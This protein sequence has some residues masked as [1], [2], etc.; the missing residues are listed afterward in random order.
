MEQEK[1]DRFE[2]LMESDLGDPEVQYQIGLCY[3][4]GE[5]VEQDGAKAEMWLQRAA[6]H[7]HPEAIAL[8]GEL[9]EP[10]V[11]LQEEVTG[12][13]LP[14][15]CNRA[16]AGDPEAQYQ[17][18][19]YFA[20]NPLPGS[21][22]EVRR[23][24][25]R[26]VEQGHGKACLSLAWELMNE[27][28]DRA[29]QLLKNA[30]DCG[31]MEALE[32]MGF[33]YA[34]G[35]G[36]PQDLAQAEQ[37]FIRW[38][39]QGDGEAK[40]ALAR[41]YKTGDLVP[42]HLGKALSWMRRAELA[43]LTDASE[44]FYAE[45]RAREA[46]MSRERERFA[47]LLAKAE[48]GDAEAQNEVG[49]CYINGQGVERDDTQAA[50]WFHKAAGQGL[51]SAQHNLGLCYFEGRGVERDDAQA[52]EWFRKA[53]EQGDANAQHDLGLFCFN[54][55]G[56]EQDNAQAAEWFHKAAEQGLAAAQYNLGI[57]YEN[58]WGV[59]QDE[60]QGA[61]W[62]R[63]AAEQGYALAQY[64][65]SLCYE[66]GQG[67]EQD[68]AQAAAWYR[69]AAEQGLAAA[70][71]NLGVCYSNGRGV[72]QDKAQAAAWYRKAAEQGLA[73]AQY[74]LGVCYSN[75][76]GVEQ[77]KAQ[78]VEWYRK[79]AEQGDAVAQ[80]SLGVCYL[81][82]R[83]VERDYAQGAEWCRKAAEQGDAAAQNDLGAC[84]EYGLGVDQDKAQ[85]V[86]WYQKAAAQGLA[87]ARE[88]LKQ[89]GV[90]E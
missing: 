18:A 19:M 81:G 55:R 27:D 20:R 77:D 74:N 82:G 21:G 78:A 86:A 25:T 29:F 88:R 75:G 46:E 37:C 7:N 15:W 22:G 10:T 69:K 47:A 33:C 89:L 54:G 9:R 66:N 40:L 58:G 2:E 70:Q 31:E 13:S 50:E 83:G 51:A 71:Y 73:A 85:A 76:R 67:V 34:Q 52:A 84:Y 62:Y 43:G 14:D 30:A 63:K 38:A 53:A 56:V 45:E 64:N 11:P 61:E 1:I 49:I 17:V 36:V 79:A 3:Q 87:P 41:R 39:Q 90:M 59:E 26:A 8:L 72:E 23:Y 60:A 65:L 12:E 16:E 5:G 32:D 24:L 6:Q 44:R 35:R 4:R 80:H 57:C 48:Q 28:P 68:K 42:K